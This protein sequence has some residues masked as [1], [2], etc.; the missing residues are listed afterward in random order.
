[1]CDAYTWGYWT[2]TLVSD[3]F[4]GLA[5]DVGFSGG[6][7]NSSIDAERY[8]GVRPVITISKDVFK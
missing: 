8:F 2:S 6:L 4:G 5:W 3:G 1:M 7:S